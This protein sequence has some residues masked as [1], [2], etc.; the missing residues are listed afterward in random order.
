MA[1]E[2]ANDGFVLRNIGALLSVWIK[3]RTRTE[4]GASLPVRVTRA[5]IGVSGVRLPSTVVFIY[6]GSPIFVLAGSARNHI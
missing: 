5:R 3:E 2:I 1:G 4:A 6:C